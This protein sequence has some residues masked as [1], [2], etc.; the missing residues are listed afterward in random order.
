MLTLLEPSEAGENIPQYYP[1][2]DPRLIQKRTLSSRA[3]LDVGT[4]E[5][6]DLMVPHNPFG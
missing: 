4:L 2:L 1:S 3:I 6:M 5:V